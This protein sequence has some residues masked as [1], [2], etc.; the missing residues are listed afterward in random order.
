M[1]TFIQVDQFLIKDCRGIL[2]RT[3]G[4]MG[5]KIP[6][7]YQGILLAGRAIHTCFMRFSLD[8]YYLNSDW[9]ITKTG[10]LAPWRFG[11][12]VKDAKLILEF[13]S[14]FNISLGRV[15]DKV[16]VASV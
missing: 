6:K 2:D 14:C 10:H 13:P 3:L 4:F 7:D 12:F 5:H 8:I 9:M 1:A 11:P 16:K 15:G